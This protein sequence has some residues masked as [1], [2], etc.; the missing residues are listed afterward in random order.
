M[1]NSLS[2]SETISLI[3]SLRDRAEYLR[4]PFRRSGPSPEEAEDSAVESE[5]E[6]DRM[7]DDLFYREAARIRERNDGWG[8]IGNLPY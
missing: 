2:S 4:S 5:R 3:A 7:S 8:K 6:A 1:S